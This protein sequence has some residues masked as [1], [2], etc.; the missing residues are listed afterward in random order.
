M[1]PLFIQN[2]GLPGLLLIAVVVLVM[3]GRGKISNLMGEVGKGITAFKKGV[4]EGKEEMDAALE[5][6]SEEAKDITPNKDKA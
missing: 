2:I 6:A 1:T 5:D 3:F 4:N